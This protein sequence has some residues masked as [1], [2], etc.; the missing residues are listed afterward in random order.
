MPAAEPKLRLAIVGTGDV[1][2]RHYLP[3]SRTS[4]AIRA[5]IKSPSQGVR[6]ER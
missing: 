1:A 2:Y 6:P 4:L 3:E 5:Q